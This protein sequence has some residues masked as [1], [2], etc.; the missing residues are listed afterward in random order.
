MLIITSK[1]WRRSQTV[2][3]LENNNCKFNH[4]VDCNRHCTVTV[5]F[6]N[7]SLLKYI[8]LFVGLV[9]LI[10]NHMFGSGDFG[11][12]SSSQFLK[13]L[14]LLSFYSGNF[15]KISKNAPG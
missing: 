6:C 13:V 1:I 12:K 14:K 8:S 7:C 10:S 4:T 9:W 5:L 2:V 15:Q 3:S 11:D